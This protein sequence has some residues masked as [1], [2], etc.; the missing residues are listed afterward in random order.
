RRAVGHARDQRPQPDPGGCSGEIAKRAVRLE[1]RLVGPVPASLWWELE[2]M[3]HDPEAVEAQLVGLPCDARQSGADAR[4]TAWPAERG[5]LEPDHQPSVVPCHG[6]TIASI[7]VI[8]LLNISYFR[9]DLRVDVESAPAYE[10]VLA[11]G[12]VADEE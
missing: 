7:F 2:E 3:I 6:R 5:Q 10:F 9:A 11:L 1:H 4:C 8:L 12:V